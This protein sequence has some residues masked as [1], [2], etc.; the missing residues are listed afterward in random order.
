MSN[1]FELCIV[2]QYGQDGYAI[3][4]RY[5][6][7]CVQVPLTNLRQQTIYVDGEDANLLMLCDKSFLECTQDSDAMCVLC[8]KATKELMAVCMGNSFHG[9]RAH[10]AELPIYIPSEDTEKEQLGKELEGGFYMIEQTLP[11]SRPLSILLQHE[12]N[13]ACTA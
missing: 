12:R 7:R 3:P 1:Q 8:R 11:S 4:I 9:Y 2:S 5:V 10:L 6:E 13:T